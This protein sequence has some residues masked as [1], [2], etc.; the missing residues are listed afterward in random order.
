MRPT[1][2]MGR[3]GYRK[4]VLQKVFNPFF[5]T[6]GEKGTGIGLSQVRAFMQMVGGRVSITSESGIGTTVDLLFPSMQQAL[7][8]ESY[9]LISPLATECRPAK[10]GT[11]MVA[12]ALA[13]C[14]A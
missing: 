10:A 5:P 6:K 11:I 7:E 14:T 2:W 13:E 12:S 4:E 1:Y 8:P 3:T 9:G